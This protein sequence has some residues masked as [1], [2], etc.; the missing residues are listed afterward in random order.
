MEAEEEF[1]FLAPDDLAHRFHGAFAAQVDAA[2]RAGRRGGESEHHRK[3]K[4]AVAKHPEFVGLSPSVPKGVTE[5]ALPSGDLLDV[6]FRHGSHWTAVEVKS[7]I[8]G[9]D[10]LSRGLF[11]CVK[12]QAVQ[13]AFLAATGRPQNVRVV[14]YL[15]TVLSSRTLYG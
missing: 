2:R 8:S 13:E 5:Y 14:L 4:N 11:K 7:H 9:E 15:D 10:D 6:L 3:L 1:D 12:Y